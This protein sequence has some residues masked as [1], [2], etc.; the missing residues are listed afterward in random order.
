MEPLAQL[1]AWQQQIT[2]NPDASAADLDVAK[3]LVRHGIEAAQ[4]VAKLRKALVRARMFGGLGKGWD[5]QV[6]MDLMAWIADGMHGPLPE[7]PAWL[8]GANA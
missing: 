6:A 7:L 3:R 5:S 1:E 4:E 2:T 8:E